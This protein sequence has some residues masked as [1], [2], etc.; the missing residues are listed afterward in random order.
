L[1]ENPL[2][3]DSKDVYTGLPE[4]VRTSPSLFMLSPGVENHTYLLAINQ[5]LG[6]IADFEVDLDLTVDETYLGI[7]VML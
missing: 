7:I 3:P 4:Y 2:K 6:D 5:S 1:D